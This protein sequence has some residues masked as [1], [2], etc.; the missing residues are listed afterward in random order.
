MPLSSQKI[1]RNSLC[2]PDPVIGLKEPVPLLMHR[3]GGDGQYDRFAVAPADTDGAFPV[4][5]RRN[6]LCQ[7][8]P[9]IGLK[10]PVPLLM[11]RAG[12]DGQYDRFAV[13]PADTDGAFPV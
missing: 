13:A 4:R 3:A 2:Q 5:S 8:D 6:S 11:H 12:G 10:E 1:R 9:V 7:P